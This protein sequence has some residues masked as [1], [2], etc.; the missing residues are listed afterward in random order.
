MGP[1]AN[2]NRLSAI[3]PSSGM[4]KP[5]GTAPLPRPCWTQ[6][7]FSRPTV[8]PTT[9]CS[10]IL[11]DTQRRITYRLPSKKGLLITSPH[12]T[13]E[14]GELPH[15]KCYPRQL[16][17]VF[18]NLL[19]NAAQAIE[20]QGEITIKTTREN[21]FIKVLITDT[22][23]GIPE[24]IQSNIFNP[25]FTTKEIGKGTGLGLSISYEIVKKHH[26]EIAVESESGKGT[27]FTIS[28]PVEE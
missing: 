1:R 24:E 22:G 11:L 10:R 6:I 13:K 25:F 15:I 5:P 7:R 3:F 8:E 4:I 9:S 16:N 2:S 12:L 14:Y 21:G 20:K 27:T 23:C 19:V 18:M 26:G 17:Q 28:L